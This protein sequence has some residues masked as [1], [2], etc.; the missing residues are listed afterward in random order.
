MLYEVITAD[1]IWGNGYDERLGDRI[2]VT[3]LATGFV[4]N[5]NS[6]NFV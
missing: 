6:Y 2:S 1:I 5:P 4:T 3:I